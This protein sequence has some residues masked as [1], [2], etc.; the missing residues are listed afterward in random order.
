MSASVHKGGLARSDGAASA[1]SVLAAAIDD[2]TAMWRT[3]GA[4]K[5]K[6]DNGSGDCLIM[7]A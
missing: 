2:K 3:L 5:L 1:A 4:I 6:H 7:A